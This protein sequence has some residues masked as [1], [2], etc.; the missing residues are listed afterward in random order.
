MFLHHV[1]DFPHVYSERSMWSRNPELTAHLEHLLKKVLLSLSVS[2]LFQSALFDHVH[3]KLDKVGIPN[4]KRSARL[5]WL[6]QQLYDSKK[7]RSKGKEAML[8]CFSLHLRLRSRDWIRNNW[9]WYR[10]ILDEN[11][12]NAY[13]QSAARTNLKRKIAA[14]WPPDSFLFSTWRYQR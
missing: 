7:R 8:R 13:F 10:V 2:A 12:Q 6:H 4:M 5:V 1:W 11:E 3:G 14:K 9:R